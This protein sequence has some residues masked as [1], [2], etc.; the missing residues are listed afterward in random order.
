MFI[1]KRLLRGKTKQTFLNTHILLIFT[2]TCQGNTCRMNLLHEY[3]MHSRY[4]LFK[5]TCH[6]LVLE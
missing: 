2:V 3:L 4:L 6:E 1:Q 5:N